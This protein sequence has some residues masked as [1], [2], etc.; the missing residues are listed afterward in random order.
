MLIW[1]F[2]LRQPWLSSWGIGVA[3]PWGGNQSRLDGFRNE[4]TGQWEPRNRSHR[5]VQPR[6][7]E[8]REYLPRNASSDNFPIVLLHKPRWCSALHIWATWY[9]VACRLWTSIVC[10]CTDYCRK[11]SRAALWHYDGSMS[12]GHRNFQSHYN[13]TGPLS[14]IWSS[15]EQ[16]VIM[17]VW[18]YYSL[19]FTGGETEAQ[20]R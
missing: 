15:I 7:V 10:H 13:L 20:R 18:L 4:R 17:R 5:H 19:H 2:L 12:P 3:W 16:N 14:N 9:P 6:L 11:L 1:Y 8:L